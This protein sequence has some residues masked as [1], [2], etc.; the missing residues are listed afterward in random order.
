MTGLGMEVGAKLIKVNLELRE[1]GQFNLSGLSQ[2]REG[3][4]KLKIV[5]S[6]PYPLHPSLG[7]ICS[8]RD[9]NGHPQACQASWGLRLNAAP[10]AE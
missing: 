1:T 6:D 10:V 7:R 3:K 4:P 8:S 9:P 5:S 2:G